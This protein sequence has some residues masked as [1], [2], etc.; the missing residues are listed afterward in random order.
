MIGY[1]VHHQGRGHLHRAMCVA[2]HTRT[3]ITGLSSLPRPESWSGEWVRLPFD[4]DPGAPQ[5]V[6][7]PGAGGR[8]HW[9]PLHHDGLRARMGAIADWI[10]RTAPSLLVSDVSAEV[11]VLARL[12]GV[13]V[14]VSDMRGDRSDP[15]H[16]LAYDIA[17]CL[18]APWP[19]ELPEPGRPLRWRRKTVHTGAFSRYDDRPRPAPAR[20]KGPPRQ[21]LVMLGAGGSDISAAQLRDAARATPRWDWQVLGG[22][23]PTWC[24]DPWPLLTTADVVITHA[25][26]NAI[27]ECAAARR[28]AVVIP[29]HRPH[30]E[31]H[32]TARALDTAGLASVRPRWPEPHEWPDV[33]AAACRTDGRRWALWAPGDGASRAAHLLDSLAAQARTGGTT[34]ASR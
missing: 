8:L 34:C 20:P 5:P 11:T 17:D 33:L 26:Q 1:Y 14:V 22:T 7:D 24:A 2:R 9:V 21:V 6:R 23:G 12:M 4:T 3:P 30:E 16:A 31:Q 27:A 28:P 25:G 32:A 10:T 18:M 29:Q 13:P 15:A 19:E